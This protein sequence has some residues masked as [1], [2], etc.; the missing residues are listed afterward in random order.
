MAKIMDSIL[1]ILSILGYWAIILG[2]SAGPGSYI[3]YIYIYIHGPQRGCHII[4]L[5]PMYIPSSYLEP[6]GLVARFASSEMTG[7]Q[8][9]TKGWSKTSPWKAK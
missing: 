9:Y 3:L 5:G 2:A 4:T 6:L 8:Q 1:L 7:P